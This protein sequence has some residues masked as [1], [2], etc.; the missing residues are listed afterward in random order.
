MSCRALLKIAP[1][2]PDLRPASQKPV[3]RE[4]CSS[5]SPSRFQQAGPI[6]SFGR[7]H[8]VVRRLRLLVGHF[9]QEQKSDLLGV[10]HLG[11]P[12]IAQD[13]GKVPSFVDDHF[14]IRHEGY[15]QV[16]QSSTSAEISSIVSAITSFEK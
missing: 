14:G 11:K 9:P 8:F 15:L 12:I 3:H 2:I 4:S 6:E 10:S 13:M 5:S 7:D 1:S 16:M